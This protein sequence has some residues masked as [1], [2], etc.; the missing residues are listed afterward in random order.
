MRHF[1][2]D[3]EQDVEAARKRNQKVTLEQVPFAFVGFG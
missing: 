2:E 1:Q 3:D